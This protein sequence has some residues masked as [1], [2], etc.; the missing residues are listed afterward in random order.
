MSTEHILSNGKKVLLRERNTSKKFST[1]KKYPT[2]SGR[3]ITVVGQTNG[4]YTSPYYVVQFEDNNSYLVK[5]DKITS[6]RIT[7]T[8]KEKEPKDNKTPWIKENSKQHKKIVYRAETQK[9]C[10]ICKNVKAIEEFYLKDKNTRRRDG[11]CKKCKVEKYK[12]NP[13]KIK[14]TP[15]YK[16]EYNKRPEVVARTK[17]YNTRPE[18]KKRTQENRKRRIQENPEL[19]IRINLSN[20]MKNALRTVGTKKPSTILDYFGCTLQELHVHLDKGEYNM[21]QYR[22]NKKWEAFFHFDHIIPSDYYL[23]KIKVD[24]EGNITKETEPW[25]YKWWNWRNLR[26]WPAG[27]NISKGADIDYALIAQHGIEDLLTIN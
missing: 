2:K 14:P 1:G 11:V 9:E 12:N 6:G 10:V 19:Q 23:K 25:L 13:N 8:Y 26:I 22:T 15:E 17:E 7:N 24:S 4:E 5:N 16:K 27:P 18:V 21:T 3:D 20:N